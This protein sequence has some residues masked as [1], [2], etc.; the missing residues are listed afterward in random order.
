MG[1]YFL[2]ENFPL[3]PPAGQFVFA[4]RMHHR[5][6]FNRFAISATCFP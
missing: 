4:S 1:L 2:A 6:P 3:A 5:G